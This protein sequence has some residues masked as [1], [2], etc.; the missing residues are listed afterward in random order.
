MNEILNYPGIIEYFP[1]YDLADKKR[2]INDY[3]RYMFA[4]TQEMFTYSGLPKSIPQRNL[5][6]QLQTRGFVGI[7]QVDGNLYSLVGGLGGEPDP[8]YLPT[9]FTVANP[10][11]KYSAML[12]IDEEVIIVRNDDTY[13]G[14]L[15]L[16]SRYATQ[17]TENDLTMLL[18]DINIR[19][20]AII[21]AKDDNVKKGAEKYLQDIKDGK[22]GVIADEIFH[23]LV[24]VQ[25]MAAQGF[26]N[27][28]TQL[29][30]YQQYLKASMFNDIGL[31]AN[32]NMK[33]EAINTSEAQMND[34]ALLPFIENMLKCRQRDFDKV[35]EMFGTD[36]QV[37]FNS[38]WKQNKEEL[39]SDP[40]D[41]QPEEE[42]E[43]DPETESES[44][45]EE[46]EVTEDETE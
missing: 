30:E 13:T 19:M 1:I 9:M 3:L 2:A 25:P 26:G 6:M 15:P 46:K 21:S 44:E 42:T 37:E 7:T 40:E 28:I 35:N 18:A 14:L 20:M 24:K 11:L 10:A 31:D 29:I 41:E 5:E 16:F 23:D 34:D 45:Q 32:Y 38:I 22:L 33:R 43:S 4:R 8:Y 36:I 39:L 17:L 12:K 27:Q